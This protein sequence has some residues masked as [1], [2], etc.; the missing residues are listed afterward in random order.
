MRPRCASRARHVAS[1]DHVVPVVGVGGL[2]DLV[3]GR[4]VLGVGVGHG[5]DP[6]RGAE[7]RFLDGGAFQVLAGVGVYAHVDLAHVSREGFRAVREEAVHM[8]QRGADD[9]PQRFPRAVP[10]DVVRIFAARVVL[11]YPVGDVRLVVGGEDVVV[12]LLPPFVDPLAQLPVVYGPLFHVR[13]FLS[14]V[15]M[16]HRPWSREAACR[17]D[18]MSTRADNRTHRRKDGIMFHFFGR[19]RGNGRKAAPDYRLLDY[20]DHLRFIRPFVQ[21]RYGSEPAQE[22]LS[23]LKD[24]ADDEWTY[25]RSRKALQPLTGRGD[26]ESSPGSS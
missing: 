16:I 15:R 12:G 9:A 7:R 18:T 25:S 19:M 2:D 8:L 17:R 1:G 13:S 10:V 26:A 3:E 24:S 21:A 5:A 6:E 20:A 4:F 22:I 14:V 11:Q 23:I